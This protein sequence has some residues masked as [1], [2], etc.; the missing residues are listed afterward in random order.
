MKGPSLARVVLLVFLYFSASGPT[1]AP[2][3]AHAD[4]LKAKKEAESRGYAFLTNRDEII[5]NAQEGREAAGARRV[6]SPND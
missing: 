1:F 3:S 4:V 5:G 6:T 2:S